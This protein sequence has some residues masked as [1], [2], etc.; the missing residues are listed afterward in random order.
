[1]VDIL[2]PII[3]LALC[4]FCL[5]TKN[6]NKY[7]IFFLIIL[8]STGFGTF[9]QR[10]LNTRFLVTDIAILVL[11]MGLIRWPKSLYFYTQN[12]LRIDL[13]ICIAIFL[14]VFFCSILIHILEYGFA[15]VYH[16]LLLFRSFFLV[17]IFLLI[18]M[19]NKKEFLALCR[20]LLYACLTVILFWF[21]Q[22]NFFS[23]EDVSSA[24]TRYGG[25]PNILFFTT[26]LILFL[27]KNL[28]I[29][30]LLLML[31]GISTAYALSFGLIGSYFLAIIVYYFLRKNNVLYFSFISIFLTAIIFSSISTFFPQVGERFLF[32][33]EDVLDYQTFLQSNFIDYFHDGSLN[34]RLAMVYE[35][36]NYVT[37]DLQTAIFGM[38]FYPDSQLKEQIFYLGTK[39]DLYLGFEQ[40][41][42]RDILYP[43][44][45]TRFGL[46]ALLIFFYV[47]LRL[48]QIEFSRGMYKGIPSPLLCFIAGSIILSASDNTYF[49]GDFYWQITICYYLTSYFEQKGKVN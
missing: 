28:T 18:R 15:G 43:N 21:F 12:T 17:A 25:Y 26:I 9:E 13:L 23:F 8:V 48:I 49:R 6:P 24:F 19:L 4:F 42:T 22:V 11:M 36:L 46:I 7:F 31:V 30:A 14:I 39:S 20:L 38:G 3:T 16:I 37:Q 27:V 33:T 34:F 32:L 5:F 1:M 29:K 10:F 45:I 41:N 35:R 2:F 40:L 44:I 47:I